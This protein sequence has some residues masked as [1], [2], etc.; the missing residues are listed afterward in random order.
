LSQEQSEVAADASPYTFEEQ[1]TNSVRD[2]AGSWIAISAIGIIASFF[3]KGGFYY[4]PYVWAVVSVW[5]WRS[6]SVAA[7]RALLGVA[8]AQLALALYSKLVEPTLSLGALWSGIL[9]L[10]AIHA[11]RSAKALENYRQNSPSIA[12]ESDSG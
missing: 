7:A 11:W 2:V 6:R 10:A 9:L 12:T 4:T 3:V 5:L 8:I 1:L